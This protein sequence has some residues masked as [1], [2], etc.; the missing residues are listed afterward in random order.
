MPILR[1]DHIYSSKAFIPVRCRVVSIPESDH[2][3]VVAD[4]IIQ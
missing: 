4:L 3:M 1:L 2:R